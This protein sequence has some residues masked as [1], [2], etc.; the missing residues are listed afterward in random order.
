MSPYVIGAAILGALAALYF[1]LKNFLRDSNT[2]NIKKSVQEK[3]DEANK[4][5]G[6]ADAAYD[7]FMRKLRDYRGSKRDSSDS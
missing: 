1:K 7:E 4:K 6:A 2:A 5:V 3:K